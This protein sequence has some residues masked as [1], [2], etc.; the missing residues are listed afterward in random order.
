[1]SNVKQGHDVKIRRSREPAC[2][3]VLFVFDMV[4]HS[5]SRKAKGR[6][7]FRVQAS[8]LDEDLVPR[9]RLDFICAVLD[10]Y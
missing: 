4:I 8:N 1:M 9:H 7:K 2:V 6:G 5:S 3:G 10:N